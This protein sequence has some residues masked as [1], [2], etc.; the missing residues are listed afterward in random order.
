MHGY[1]A[2]GNDFGQTDLGVILFY[3][4]YEMDMT[5]SLDCKQSVFRTSEVSA[6]IKSAG[7]FRKPDNVQYICFNIHGS[8]VKNLGPQKTP[9]KPASNFLDFNR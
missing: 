1:S 2:Q 5:F 7:F 9:L 8:V 3:I 6:G 4:C